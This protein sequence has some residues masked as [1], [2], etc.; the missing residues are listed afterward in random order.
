MVSVPASLSFL[1][2]FYQSIIHSICM[3]I[4]GWDP[5]CYLT[6]YPLSCV[7]TVLLSG[8][9]LSSPQVFPIPYYTISLP[10]DSLGDQTED[11]L[12]VCM[13]ALVS[14]A[15]FLYTQVCD[16][17]QSLKIWWHHK[18]CSLPFACLKQA[19]ILP[20]AKVFVTLACLLYSILQSQVASLRAI[21]TEGF[22]S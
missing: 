17:S 18:F 5:H 7:W 3:T 6:V 4:T 20:C 13:A 15:C 14:T 16:K 22:L 10:L 2:L 11:T 19:F 21:L 8:A 1:L 9:T 12:E